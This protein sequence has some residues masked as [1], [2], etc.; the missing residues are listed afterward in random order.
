MRVQFGKHAE[1]LS[2]LSD[3]R[4]LEI[5]KRWLKSA[6]VSPAI[7]ERHTSCT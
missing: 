7:D 5:E 2:L 1:S 6:F 4:R 3:K